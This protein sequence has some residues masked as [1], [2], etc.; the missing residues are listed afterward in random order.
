MDTLDF[1]SLM[2][3]KD[4]MCK[5]NYTYVLRVLGIYEIKNGTLLE[6]GLM[7]EYM[8]HGS[9]HS[10]FG[11]VKDI[12]WALRFQ[13]LHQVALGMNYL[14]H[15]LNPPIIHRDLKP[16]NVLLN[17]FLDVQLTD[18]GLARSEAS[19][20]ATFAGTLSYMPPEAFRPG[21]KATQ[22][23]DVYSF[24]ILTWGILAGQEPYKVVN[25][26]VVEHH[27]C[28]NDRP[29]VQQL[30]QWKDVKMV[31]EAIQMMEKCWDGD[32]AARPTFNECKDQTWEMNRQYVDEIQDAVIT[33]LNQLRSNS[34]SSQ[35][36]QVSDVPDGATP[37][38]SDTDLDTYK[39]NLFIKSLNR[40]PDDTIVIEDPQKFL[41]ENFSKIIQE[42]PELTGV[43]DDLFAQNYLTGEDM[44]RI[45]KSDSVHE[46]I[47]KTLRLM[48]N[49]GQHSCTVFLQLLRQ[50]CPSLMSKLEVKQP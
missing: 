35:R 38:T 49:N 47:R 7:M 48:M 8:P 10:L 30:A 24:A 20:S 41:K 4:L 23:F 27:V 31:P 21:Y 42:K 39:I 37:E 44:D 9:L 50:H 29:D 5:A 28:K 19:V 12:P 14:H 45:I 25:Q 33:V 18:F 43:W 32:P 15:A 17:K 22:K 46:Q 40:V 36:V 26:E 16:H 11:R 34:S 3:E 2:K 6:Y 1:E 13:F